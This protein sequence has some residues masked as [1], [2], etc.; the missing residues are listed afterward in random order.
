MKSSFHERIAAGRANYTTD[1]LLLELDRLARVHRGFRER[2]V[3]EWS[4]EL[5]HTDPVRE[6]SYLRHRG[7]PSLPPSPLTTQYGFTATRD[8]PSANSPWL[9]TTSAPLAR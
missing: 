9:L 6:A 3:G 5:T 1:A 7:E 2:K 8:Y 4:V